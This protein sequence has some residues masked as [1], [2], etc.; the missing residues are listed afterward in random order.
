MDE[1]LSTR[2]LTMADVTEMLSRSKAWG[3]HASPSAERDERGGATASVP[4][5]I[6]RLL[7]H[8]HVAAVY[9]HERRGPPEIERFVQAVAGARLS[10]REIEL[11]AHGFFRGTPALRQAIDQ[12]R[13]KWTLDQ[14]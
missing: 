12:G 9:A 6:P 2:Q 11:L 3:Q 7:V 5:R 13:W 14:M 4:R 10:V 8:G 1:L